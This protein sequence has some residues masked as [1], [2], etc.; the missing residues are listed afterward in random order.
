MT[1]DL[2]INHWLIRLTVA[3]LSAPQ[4]NEAET[5]QIASQR[6]YAHLDQR[7]KTR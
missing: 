7:D 3:M 2:P 6:R 4:A 1:S 5:G